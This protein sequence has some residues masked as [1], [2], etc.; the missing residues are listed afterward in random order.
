MQTQVGATTQWASGSAPPDTNAVTF[1]QQMMYQDGNWRVEMNGSGLL[2]SV[3][4]PQVARMSQGRVNDYV[5]RTAYDAKP[6]GL[7]LRFG[8]LTPALYLDSQFVTA[9]TPRQGVEATLN[10]P[11]GAFAYFVNTNDIA[12]GGGS[13][14]T[15]HQELMGASWQ[16][17]L[18]KN[19]AEFRLMWLSA[20]DLGVPTTVSYDSQGHPIITPNPLGTSSAGDA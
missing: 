17:P 5:L 9:A 6:W 19:I 15:F 4:N 16:A 12:L 11:A 3:L 1:G 20:Q 2:N 10:T 7:N 13:G 8:I 14:I 18:P